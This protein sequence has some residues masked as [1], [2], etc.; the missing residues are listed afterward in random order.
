[1]RTIYMADDGKQF[2]DK[3]DC[4]DYEFGMRIKGGAKQIT[5]IDENGAVVHTPLTSEDTYSNAYK[6]IVTGMLGIRTLQEISDYTG[7]IGYEDIDTPGVWTFNKDD[8]YHHYEK[9]S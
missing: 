3:Y 9:I 4:L 6:I 7:F 2:D 8:I 1:M 5:I